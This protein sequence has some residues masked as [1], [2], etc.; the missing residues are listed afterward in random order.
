M[1]LQRLHPCRGRARTM[2][3]ASKQS[4]ARVYE[5]SPHGASKQCSCAG[6]YLALLRS[7]DLQHV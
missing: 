3:Q 6:V 1:R 7:D 5:L 4:S 2:E